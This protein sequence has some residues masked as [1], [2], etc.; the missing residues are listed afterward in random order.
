VLIDGE[1]AAVLSRY[2]VGAPLEASRA[3]HGYVNETTIIRTSRGR[4]VVR[5]NHRRFAE[6]KLRYRHALL[7]WLHQRFAPVPALIA[8]RDGDTLVARGGRFYEVHAYVEGEAYDP[9]RP[10]QLASI[11][12]TLACY[13]E[14]V[15]GFPALAAEAAPRY[16]P[17]AVCGLAEQLIE[18]DVMGELHDQLGWYCARAGQLR[19]QLPEAAYHALPH[20]VIH[21][22]IHSDNLRFCG[23]RVAALLDFDQVCWD[24]RLVD[25]ADALVAFASHPDEQRGWGV[26]AGPIDP[27]RATQL[28]AAYAARSPLTP[29]ETAALVPLVE[30]V[31][32]Q[33]ELGRVLSTPEGAPEYHR[34]VLEQGRAL[35][36]WLA[37]YSSCVRLNQ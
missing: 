28:L 25:L 37:D 10:R 2:D 7:D 20:L 11:G 35:S 16:S 34:S 13:H 15:R 14:A 33:G 29:H 22:D 26:F 1:I 36:A 24:A 12:A 31:W 8:N 32:L 23:D 9:H 30:L 27:E 19:A 18:R 5:R 17:Y 4:F 6:A 21:G 3:V